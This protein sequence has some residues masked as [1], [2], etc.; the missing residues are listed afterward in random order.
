MRSNL[1]KLNMEASK[2][3]QQKRGRLR[4]TSSRASTDFTA[5]TLRPDL[6]KTQELRE[7]EASNKGAMAE[8]E[9]PPITKHFNYEE[10]VKN[11]NKWYRIG[12]YWAG[13]LHLFAEKS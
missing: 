2:K 9:K 7:G 6:P 11:L 8:A 10:T 1:V 3:L 12:R 4:K 5:L 13:D